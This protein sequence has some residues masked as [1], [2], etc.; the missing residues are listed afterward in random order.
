MLCTLHT[1]FF[2]FSRLISPERFSD[3]V[4]QLTFSLVPFRMHP[5]DRAMVTVDQ[6]IHFVFQSVPPSLPK[7]SETQP[8]DPFSASSQLKQ[9]VEHSTLVAPNEWSAED[10]A[11]YWYSQVEIT[12]HLGPLR[13]VWMGPQFT[14]RTY[15]QLVSSITPCGSVVCICCTGTVSRRNLP[16]WRCLNSECRQLRICT[17]LMIEFVWKR[18][19][20]F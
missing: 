7:Q 11:S 1:I 18:E 20:A 14:F 10:E 2:P 6:S 9:P 4:D 5:I 17:L 13:R 12:T 16:A 8:S 15:S 3:E 19:F